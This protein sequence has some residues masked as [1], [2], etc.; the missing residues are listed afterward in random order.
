MNIYQHKNAIKWG[1]ALAALLIG[2]SSLLYTNHLVKQLAMR[3]T[4]Q[5]ELYA[6]AQELI[7][8][9][10][11]EAQKFLFERIIEENNSIPVILT[12]DAGHILDSRNVP[13]PEKAG[14]EE[15]MRLLERE[16]RLMEASGYAP[17]RIA[18][19]EDFVQFVYYRN[20]PLITQL[21]YYPLAQ[22][23]AL[24][25]LGVLAY[26]IFSTARRAEQNRVWVGLAKETAH[27]LGTPI[28]SL[29][30]WVEYFRLDPDFDQA[31]ADEMDKDIKRLEM[32]TARFS[33]I[34]SV[35]VMQEADAAAVV[36]GIVAYLKP[37]ISSKV[38]IK[39]TPRVGQE[40]LAIMNVP[41]FEWVIENLCKNAVDAM[42]G[43]GRIEIYAR[44]SRDARYVEIDISDTGK[45][46]T[47]Q[48]AK[49][50]FRPGFTTKKRG[51]GLGL[52]LAK[53]IVED[54][55][56]G[57]IYVKRSEPGMGTTFRIQVPRIQWGRMVDGEPISLAKW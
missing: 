32:I 42:N 14:E 3:E 41:L 31:V 5:I 50:V 20:S 4:R 29:M 28:S 46:M 26:I 30:A 35:P 55:H 17:L 27:Q 9:T 56:R 1:I 51:W 13:L 7:V 45:G 38:E 11:G 8:S 40:L 12:D 37:R 52:T 48:V 33:S 19:D 54:Y 18:V 2:L 34:G 44:H 16:L 24:C 6:R 21:Q 49:Q 22:M 43:S 57:R 53:R 10:S 25:L 15:R 23:V 47:P 36:S 39:F